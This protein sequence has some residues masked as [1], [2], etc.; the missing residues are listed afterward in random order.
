MK[1]SLLRLAGVL[2]VAAGMVAVSVPADAHQAARD[3]QQPSAAQQPNDMQ[4]QDAKPFSGTIV[5]EKGKFVLKDAATKMSYQLDDQDKAKQFE[6]KQ[7]KVTGKLDLDTNLIHVE[8]IQ[9]LS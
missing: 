9:P 8:N 7:V 1:N 6:G 4:T 2:I 3:S 5:K